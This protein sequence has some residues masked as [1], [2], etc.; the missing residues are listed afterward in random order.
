MPPKKQT[1]AAKESRKK[2]VD[3]KAIEKA[4]TRITLVEHNG[5]T[6]DIAVFKDRSFLIR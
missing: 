3:T 2:N 5:K 6:L 1:L 4:T